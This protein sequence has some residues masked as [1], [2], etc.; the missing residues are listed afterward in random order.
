M[1]ES[2]DPASAPVEMCSYSENVVKQVKVI[3]V[4]Q[5][6]QAQGTSV[7]VGGLYIHLYIERINRIPILLAFCDHTISNGFYNDPLFLCC[8]E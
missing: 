7:A 4:K 8:G 5:V 1:E 3:G 2:F 6:L